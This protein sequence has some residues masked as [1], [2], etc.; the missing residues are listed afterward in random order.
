[1]KPR[2]ANAIRESDTVPYESVVAYDKS[3]RNV[4]PVPE[5]ECEEGESAVPVPMPGRIA[6]GPAP[7]I[8]RVGIWRQRPSR[9]PDRARAPQAADDVPP[10]DG[11]DV[12]Q[13]PGLIVESAAASADISG[14]FGDNT[15][16]PIAAVGLCSNCE[17]R[18]TCTFAKPEGGVWRCDE[19]R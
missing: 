7:H 2:S 4:R 10:E 16:E 6:S 12:L 1:M 19:Y 3:E 15:R 18:S 11:G 17:L 8:S 9:T 5:F 13:L 14:A